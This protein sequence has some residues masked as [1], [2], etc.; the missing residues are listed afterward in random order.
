MAFIFDN[1][2]NSSC[3]ACYSLDN[4]ERYRSSS[5][6]IY[7]LLA[8]VMI[9]DSGVVFAA[10]YDENLNVLHK[11]LE[12]VSEISASQGSKYAPSK[13]VGIFSAVSEAARSQQVLFVG[14][15]CQCAGLISY[16]E[17][18]QS[19]RENVTIVDFVCHGVPSK[20]AWEG[21]KKSVNNT[22]GVLKSVNMR[23]KSSGW[24]KGNYSWRETLEDGD[25][26]I[27]PRREAPFMK[28]MLANIYLRPS[29]YNCRF[30][31]VDRKTDLTLGDYWG[32]WNHDPEMDDDMGTSL[33]F[34]HTN[35][36]QEIFNKIQNNI[37]YKQIDIENAVQGNMCIISSTPYSN[38]RDIF[39]KRIRNNE[40]F[41]SVVNDMTRVT[42][43]IRCKRLM[44]VIVR[45]VFG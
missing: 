30:K 11:R 17:S 39:F 9:K 35:K 34:V 4:E 13:L 5:G 24:S 23:D 28:G 45:K 22:L 43:T 12:S 14:T 10:C 19:K 32:V 8:R 31:G 21:Y 25:T 41:V 20:I 26:I 36:G 1:M 27:T 2:G 37:Q 44:K 42:L 18:N 40:D 29:C 6:G 3:Y 7:P 15:P 16:L 33:L 38:K